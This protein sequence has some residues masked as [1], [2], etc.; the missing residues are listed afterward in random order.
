[1]LFR[2]SQWFKA[3][4][5]G[6][7]II[8]FPDF[9]PWTKLRIYTGG[10][11]YE[12]YPQTREI[13]MQIGGKKEQRFNLKAGINE[14]EMK[15]RF[16]ARTYTFTFYKFE[17]GDPFGGINELQGFDGAR[18]YNIE[19]DSTFT[20]GD[21]LRDSI[22]NTPL[23]QILNN[24]VAYEYSYTVL[25][26]DTITRNV[27]QIDS[28]LIE[29]TVNQKTTVVLRSNYT[30][31]ATIVTNT[32]NYGKKSSFIT[33]KK[34]IVGDFKVLSKNAEQVVLNVRYKLG[35]QTTVD[36]KA[37]KLGYKIL[38]QKMTI[39]KTNVVLPGDF[40]MQVSY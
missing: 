13:G 16:V 5:V 17:E 22:I 35:E 39:T 36:G 15:E 25:N 38:A 29:K 31:E 10:T 27:Q 12:M 21:A 2:S 1:M 40:E 4:G 8:T 33:N 30:W 9:T 20:R 7:M 19:P 34:W 26:T 18:W 11:D 23:K 32:V 3:D 24:Q 37:G 28:R 6:K 14:L